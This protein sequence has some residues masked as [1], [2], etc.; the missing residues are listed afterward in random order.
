M[1]ILRLSSLHNIATKHI[2][3]KIYLI[4]ISANPHA[5][6]CVEKFATFFSYLLVIITFPFSLLECFKV[7]FLLHSFIKTICI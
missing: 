5:V 7:I 1:Y 3:K 6:G 2:K 4:F